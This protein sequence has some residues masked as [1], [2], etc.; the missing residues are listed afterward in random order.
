MEGFMWRFHSQ[1]VRAR[2]AI[3]RGAIGSVRL[4]EASFSFPLARKPNVRLKSSLAGGSIM[5]VGCYPISAA[6]FYFADEP[7]SAFV[8]AEMDAEY[9]VDMRAAGILEFAG[10]S[11]LI[12]CGFN[13][14]YRTHLEIVGDTGVIRIPQPWLPDPEAVLTI[15]GESQKLEAQNQYVNEFEHFSRCLLNGTR[16][17]YGPDDAVLQMAAIDAVRRSFSQRERVM[18]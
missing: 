16:P 13:L 1:H 9:G 11:A 17:A 15:N 3:E 18:L 7:V 2:A 14:P 5:D 8:R 4:I 6:R 12:D 10:G